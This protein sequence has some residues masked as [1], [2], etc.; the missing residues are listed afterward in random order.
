MGAMITGVTVTELR[1]I[2]NPNGDIRHAMK[3]SSPGYAGFGEAYFSSIH[4]GAIKGWKRHRSA[5]LNLVVP[6]GNVRFV[7]H[8]DRQGSPSQGRFQEWTLGE[9]CY[10]RLTVEP[11]L[12]VAFQGRSSL[13]SMLLNISN[14][15][16]DPAEADNRDLQSFIY[17]W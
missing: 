9:E 3:V 4:P 17:S 8:D 1:R 7:I 10:A 5:T 15:E 6:V 2:A 11:G 16:H 14:E 13:D 12:W